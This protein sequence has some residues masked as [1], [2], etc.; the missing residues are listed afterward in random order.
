M[1]NKR[2]MGKIIFAIICIVIIVICISIQ[3]IMNKETKEMQE[4]SEK[5]EQFVL[6]TESGQE[7]ETEYTH[8]DDNQFYI[9]IPTN[10][11]QLDIETISKK[12]NGEIPNIVFSNDETTINIAI[13]LTENEMTDKQIKPYKEYMEK[14]LENNSEIIDSDYYKVDNHNI[15]Q[16]KLMT[17]ATDTNIYN[18][19]IFFSYHDKLVIVTFNCTDNLKNEWQEVGDRIIDSLFFNE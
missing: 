12:Y 7:I 11:Q 1:K 5:L 3:I 9:K 15:G 10:F 6:Q 16:I 18:N 14:I 19:M 4:R 13:S 2:T 8:V 17:K